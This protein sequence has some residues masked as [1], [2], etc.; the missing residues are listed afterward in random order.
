[1]TREKLIDE[2]IDFYVEHR[3]YKSPLKAFELIRTI[4]AQ[5]NNVAF[6]ETLYNE[7]FIKAKQNKLIKTKRIKNML[8]E[9]EKIRIELE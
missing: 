2:I 5:L 6:V 3:V 8:F 9:L 4:E 7:I 1:M